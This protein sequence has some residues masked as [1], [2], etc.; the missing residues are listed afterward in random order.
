MINVSISI[1]PVRDRDGEIVGGSKI[2][3]DITKLTLNARQL[4]QRAALIDLSSDA[5]II[6]DI[7]G[8]I[9]AWSKGAERLYG[10]TATEAVGQAAHTLLATRFSQPL[11]DI[12]AAFDQTGS[13][14]GELVHT[15]RDGRLVTVL[16]RWQ[17]DEVYDQAGRRMLETNT[18]ITQLKQRQAVVETLLREVNHRSKNMLGLVLAIARQTAKGSDGEFVSRFSQRIHALAASHDLLV[19]SEWTGTTLADLIRSQLSHFDGLIGT[20][21]TLSGDAIRV[22]MVAAQSIGMALH[23]MATNAA[24]YGALSHDTGK[25]EI[26]W[27]RSHEQPTTFSMSW[28]EMGGPKVLPPQRRGFGTTVIEAMVA[29]SLDGCVTLDYYATGFQWQVVCPAD[30]VTD[31]VETYQRS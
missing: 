9:E 6:R 4:E 30:K 12:Q 11:A 24:K 1:S 16:T 5:I 20:R 31:F 23:E 29:A 18:D 14:Q 10:F 27:Q 17:R 25:V 22:N 8:T 26:V 13:W 3:R 21:I 28:R 7:D 15:S 2:V 19:E